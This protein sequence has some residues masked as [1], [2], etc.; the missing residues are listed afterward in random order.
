MV[1]RITVN[2]A[3]MG[4]YASG[5]DCHPYKMKDGSS[6]LPVPTIKVFGSKRTFSILF[7]FL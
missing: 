6:N 7:V 2:A 4:A 3:F 1:G 5:I